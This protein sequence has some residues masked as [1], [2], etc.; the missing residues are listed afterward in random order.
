[1]EI[2]EKKIDAIL[3][4]DIILHPIFRQDGLILIGQYKKITSSLLNHLKVHCDNDFPVLVL[5]NEVEY[6]EFIRTSYFKTEEF[7]HMLRNIYE[8][9]KSYLTMKLNFSSY[10]EY[11][12]AHGITNN[13]QQQPKTLLGFLISNPSWT[14]L[15]SFVSSPS[16][17]QRARS[18][19]LSITKALQ[20]DST[21]HSLFKQ[22]SNFHSALLTHSVNTMCEALSIGLTLELTNEELK[23]LA[24]STLFADIGYT[25]MDIQKFV[26]M[27]NTGK[28]NAF[29]AEHIRQ[30]IDIIKDSPACRA[31][32]VILGILD[33]HEKFDG[34]GFPNGKSGQEISLF[35]RII[36]ISQ[37]YDELAGGYIQ[38]RSI[39]ILAAQSIIWEDR[40]TK[41]DNQ[42]LSA[43]VYRREFC[44]LGQE[45]ILRDN[46]RGKIV[47][48]E[49]FTNYPLYPTVEIDNN[50]IDFHKTKNLD[51]IKS[52]L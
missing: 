30:S 8:K 40:G 14:N 49:D 21:I 9:H 35:G 32:S 16:A 52:I 47:G 7:V 26:D 17:T 19:K 39:P 41:W 4:G 45:V 3:P 12:E 1:M 46:R 10:T 22:I 43:F 38:E 31:R 37:A 2:I 13:Q 5:E 51:Y 36:A 24:F 15:E 44:K 42:I 11:A 50:K 48:F 33:H 20:E 28:R 6:K 18:V 23:N 27:L 29:I 34:S 25:R